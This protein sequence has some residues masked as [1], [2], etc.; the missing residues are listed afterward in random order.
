[1][2]TVPLCMD[3]KLDYR[4]FGVDVV[5]P[6]SQWCAIHPDVDG[7]LCGTCIARRVAKLQG[8]VVILAVVEFKRGTCRTC[9]QLRP[10]SGDVFTCPLANM[11]LHASSVDEFGCIHH[12][13]DEQKRWRD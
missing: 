12:E 5:L 10:L 6:W 3:C 1:M 11:R 4:E 9:V 8:A 13:T 2:T 7:I